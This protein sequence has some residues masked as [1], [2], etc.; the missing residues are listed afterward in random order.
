MYALTM[1]S[2]SREHSTNAASSRPDATTTRQAAARPEAPRQSVMIAF[3]GGPNAERAIAYA[4]Q[5]LRA[6]VAHV[7]TAWQP[8]SL[9]P[10]RMST[11]SAGIQP[12][13]D[14]S[15]L[16]VEVDDAL[17]TEAVEINENGVALAKSHGLD[18]GGMLVEVESTVWGALV[19]A[20]D[21]LNVDLL[22]IGTRG[23][24]GFKALLHSDVAGAVLKHCHRPVFIVP[25]QCDKQPPVVTP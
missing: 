11:L 2:R 24:S 13:L 23:S 21:D 4:S 8:G 22:V 19:A 7:V 3:D 10:A 16:A 5:F 12:F 18:A 17:R 9:D 14:T 25:A 20:A 1:D 15:A 6:S